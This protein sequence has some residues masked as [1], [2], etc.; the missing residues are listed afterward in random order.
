[1]ERDDDAAAGSAWV[2]EIHR[3]RRR[4]LIAAATGVA[5]LAAGGG[6]L[7]A[8]NARGRAAYER[9]VGATWRHS[10]HTDQPL[11]DVRR[12]LVRYATLAASSHNTQPWR[13]RFD[14]GGIVVLPDLRRRCHAVDPDD[15]HLF[16]S[17]GCA[18]ENIVQAAAA[19]GLRA[20][21]AFDVAGGGIRIDLTPDAPR[22][23]A[24]F[25][26]IPHRQCTRADYE[27]RPLS[28]VHLRVLDDAG[29]G[30]GV[31]ML[32]FSERVQREQILAYLVAANS[33]QMDDASFVSELKSWIRFSYG[34]ALATRDG[35]FSKASGNPVVPGPIGRSLFGLFFTKQA[36]NRKYEHQLRNS[37][38]IAVFV[39]EKNDPA[40]WVEAGRCYQ[41]FALQAT[42]L[43]LRHAFIN[44][45][46]EVAAVRGQFATHLGLDG[47]RPDLVV[48]FGYGPEMPRSL[49]RPVEDVI[50]R[51]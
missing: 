48:R 37:A 24:L 29:N 17:L 19:F 18:S 27:E 4:F 38:G 40:H 21:P 2:S 41:R 33:A 15:H 20:R 1:M 11:S 49:R 14:E 12:E 42:A 35:L 51:A 9:A 22:R 13:F 26:A 8:A 6:G 31:R 46:V 39:S 34:E 16:V 23:T 43:Q 30:E 36:E 47:R 5:T 44:Q 10:D 28:P 25:E 7:F 3:G 45:P 32:M 50:L